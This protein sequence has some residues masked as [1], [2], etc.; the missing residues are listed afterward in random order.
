MR[1]LDALPNFE[2]ETGVEYIEASQT[3]DTEIS[4]KTNKGPIHARFMINAAG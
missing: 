1:Q 2:T 3:K 4:V